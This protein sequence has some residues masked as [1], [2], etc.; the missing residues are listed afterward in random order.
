MTG[1]AERDREKQLRTARW[2]LFATIG[3]IAYGSFY[4]FHFELQRLVDARLSVLFYLPQMR[5]LNYSDIVG[6][7]LLYI[8]LGFTAVHALP[9]RYGRWR[10][11]V[12]ALLLGAL[13]SVLVEFLQQATTNR[14]ASILDVALNVVSTIAGIALG[15]SLRLDTTGWPHLLRRRRPH[16]M[17]LL[18]VGLW[19]AAHTIP[20]VPTLSRLLQRFE[21]V[22][23]L[24]F[25]PGETATWVAGYLIVSLALRSLVRR[26]V[27]WRA[28]VALVA[29]SL[30][31]RLF[32]LNQ[33]LELDECL[34]LALAFVPIAV[35]RSIR[36]TVVMRPAFY[37]V[38][39][40]LLVAGL[41]PYELAPHVQPFQWL[42]FSGFFEAN[43]EGGYIE[44]TRK[45]FL[46]TGA[47]WLAAA[48]AARLR[49]AVLILLAVTAVTEWTQRFMPGRTPT[50]T[51]WVLVLVGALIVLVAE[52]PAFR[53]HSGAAA[54]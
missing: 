50:I 4:P 18:L 36:Y 22:R 2:L 41:Q 11:A 28:W 54:P 46:Y 30:A 38:W 16:A 21:P 27:F 45:L 48:D 14:T 35:T 52:M 40:L 9:D 15:L 7:L 42:P 26:H 43:G 25:S 31:A 23:T 39:A 6:N 37:L 8:P 51:D 3:L 13:L 33:R 10:R 34:G 5:R 1:T 24:Q 17:P 32:F 53:A 49:N 19:I 29:G 44:S 47:L 20:F 12:L